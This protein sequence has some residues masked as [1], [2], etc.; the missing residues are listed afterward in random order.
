MKSQSSPPNATIHVK[1]ELLRACMKYQ[2]TSVA[3]N[4]AIPSAAIAL[5]RPRSKSETDL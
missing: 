5:S 4:P 2:T 3:L 1:R